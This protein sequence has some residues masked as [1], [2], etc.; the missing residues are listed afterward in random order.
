LAQIDHN[1][2]LK[3]DLPQCRVES[4]D[5]EEVVKLFKELDFKSLIPQLP[6]DQFEAQVQDS[7]F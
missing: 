4:F 1:V 7:L 5:K 2:P 3:I 6:N